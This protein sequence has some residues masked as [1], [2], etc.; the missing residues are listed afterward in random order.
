MT[1]RPDGAAATAE[2]GGRFGVVG[3]LRDAFV[4]RGALVGGLAFLV[5]YAL[6]VLLAR[7]TGALIGTREPFEV[8]GLVFYGAHFVSGTLSLPTGVQAVDAIGEVSSTVPKVVFYLVPVVVLTAASYLFV[9]RLD[10]SE[11]RSPRAGARA[12][13]SIVAGYLP[14]AVSGALLV[15]VAVP[16][17]ASFWATVW[18]VD[19][20]GAVVL[21][22][23]VYPVAFG[24]LGGSLA[25]RVPTDRFGGRDRRTDGDATDDAGMLAADGGRAHSERAPR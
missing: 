12:G 13:V 3:R 23:V 21:A 1:E 9:S 20:F 25:V 14:L 22:G 16:G 11:R 4:L 17:A 18:R 19:L 8:A 7:V 24:A 5:G 6:T 15:S 2:V 10:E